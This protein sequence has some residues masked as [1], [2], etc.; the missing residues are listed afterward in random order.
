MWIWP[1]GETAPQRK[2]SV[3]TVGSRHVTHIHKDLHI[4]RIWLNIFCKERWTSIQIYI[5]SSP[6]DLASLPQWVTHLPRVQLWSMKCIWASADSKYP[7]Q[8]PTPNLSSICNTSHHNAFLVTKHNGDEKRTS[9]RAS[10]KQTPIENVPLLHSTIRSTH[11]CF[12]WRPFRHNY[13][14]LRD[15]K[16]SFTKTQGWWSLIIIC[17]EDMCSIT[18]R[19]DLVEE[20]PVDTNFI[21][22]SR[23]RNPCLFIY[24][25]V[26][27]DI[28]LYSNGSSGSS[29]N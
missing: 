7:S 10:F 9:P 14:Q 3:H 20:V 22:P 12:I 26:W 18:R 15:M 11:Y 19:W 6:V 24:G 25:C 27:P 5:K 16:K 4:C 21:V 8:S 28:S 13:I 1:P 23:P 17:L 29:Q 2:A